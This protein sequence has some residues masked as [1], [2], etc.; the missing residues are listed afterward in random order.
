MS[1]NQFDFAVFRVKRE[2][3]HQTNIHCDD[4]YSSD[5]CLT[6]AIARDAQAVVDEHKA[7]ALRCLTGFDAT[8][9]S[10]T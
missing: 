5:N 2:H 4:E 10:R 9:E 1:T 7:K 8:S 3:L 6:V